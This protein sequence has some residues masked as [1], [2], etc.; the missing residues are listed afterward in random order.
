M[1]CAYFDN[2]QLLHGASLK[3]EVDMVT[4]LARLDTVMCG[5][6]DLRHHVIMENKYEQ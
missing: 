6:H 2:M 4:H 1:A 5:T 3:I